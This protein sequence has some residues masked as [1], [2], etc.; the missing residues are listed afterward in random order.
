MAGW[1]KDTKGSEF[2]GGAVAGD[3]ADSESVIRAL[4]RDLGLGSSELEPVSRDLAPLLGAFLN[5]SH[6]TFTRIALDL[7][8]FAGLS[9]DWN[10]ALRFTRRLIELRDDRVE[11]KLWELRCLVECGRH[12]EAVALNQA[13]PWHPSHRLHVNYLSGLA[14][15][16]LGLQEQ[17]R[18]R[19]DAVRRQ[20]P[21]YRDVASKL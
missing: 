13:V 1:T 17:A 4:G 16:S 15:E 7:A 9:G 2:G 14:L 21:H 12:A 18:S 11:V 19:F 8:V 3:T 5:L 6:L 20:D 10:L